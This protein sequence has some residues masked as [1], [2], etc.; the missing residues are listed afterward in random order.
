M[1]PEYY[2]HEKNLKAEL[3]NYDEGKENF[4]EE[5]REEE[6]EEEK[7]EVVVGANLYPINEPVYDRITDMKKIELQVGK[8]GNYAEKKNSSKRII[9]AAVQMKK[10]RDKVVEVITDMEIHSENLAL[11][12][13]LPADDELPV[14]EEIEGAIKIAFTLRN[15]IDESMS[16]LERSLSQNAFEHTQERLGRMLLPCYDDYVDPVITDEQQR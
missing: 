12:V 1:R 2:Q 15:S 4:L 6:V 3:F 16:D 13:N 7:Y 8:W 11:Y 9:E 5:E 10:L 14:Y